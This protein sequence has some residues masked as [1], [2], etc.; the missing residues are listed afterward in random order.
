MT[1][2]GDGASPR[3]ALASASGRWLIAAAALGSGVAFLDGSVVNVALPAIGR[4]LG[5]GLSVLQWVLDG[6]LLTLSALLLLGGALGDRYDRRLV[7]LAG[8]VVF[9]IASVGCGLAPTG[10]VLILARIVQGIGGA[11]LVPSSLA[12][13][14]TVIRP[15]DRGRAIGLWAGLS[16]VSSAIG[17][18]VGGWL[19]DAASWRWVFL[20]NV[21]LAAAA[22]ILTV[23]HVPRIRDTR[24]RGPLDVAGAAAVTIGLGGITFA[25]IEAPVQGWTPTVVGALVV[26]V[27]AVAAFP[28]VE[29]RAAD[30]LVPLRLFRS[31]QFSGTNIVTLAVYT[32]LGGALFLLSLHLQANLGYGA[33]QAGLAFVPFTAI[34]LVL[35]GRMGALAQRTGP[36]ALMTAGPLVAGIGLALLVRVVPG[37]TYWGGVL[38][39]ILVFGLGMAMT[40][41]PLTATVLEAVPAEYVGAASGANNAISR[42]ASLLAVAVL[43]L[44]VGITDPSGPSLES[45]FA[46]AMLVSA[47]LCVIGG[48]VAFATVRNPAGAAQPRA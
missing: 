34:M 11:L 15:E 16:G 7:F 45:G 43:P 31:P 1:F 41:A 23:R 8:L 5:G 33:L 36:R 46:R 44:A 38:P 20:I 39:G 27:L 35:S 2:G 13:I 48:A 28:V 17:P 12:M 14:E 22:L 29:H 21:P 40:V 18:F 47:A 30:P 19:V 32:G 37:A 4:D 9:T 3:L 25:L 42:F 6:Y 26:G 24:V 10:E